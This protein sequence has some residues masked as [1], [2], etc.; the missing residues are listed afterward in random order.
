[1]V[2]PKGGEKQ[3]KTTGKGICSLREEGRRTV[4][5]VG[6]GMN[7]NWTNPSGESIQKKEQKRGE[8]EGKGSLGKF[9]TPKVGK[10]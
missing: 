9:V 6:V 8:T 2:G 7:K 3:R 1:V 10:K 5:L 4:L